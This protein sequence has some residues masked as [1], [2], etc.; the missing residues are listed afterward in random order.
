MKLL[1]QVLSDL[2]REAGWVILYGV[3]TAMVIMA[4]ILIYASYQT[5]EAKNDSISKFT[6][7]GISFVQVG[8]AQYNAPKKAPSTSWDGG[9]EESLEEYFT[10]IFSEN[11]CGGT[12]VF[13]W[14]RCGY[15][16]VIILL[17][18]YT[19]L[20]P[21][22][23][24]EAE[25][26]TFAVSHD[27]KDTKAETITF[28]GVDYPLYTAPENMEIYHPLFYMDSD[29]LLMENTLFVFTKDYELIKSI[30]PKS[31]YWEIRETDLLSR[32]ILASPSQEE[33]VRLRNVV[34]NSI[35]QYVSVQSVDAFLQSTTSSGLRT[36][37]T[38]LLFYISATSILLGAMLVNI[39]RILQRKMPE[40]AVHHL[41][42][43]SERFLYARML[44][45]SVGYH[46][47]PLGACI[48]ILERN[49]MASA[50]TI[51]GLILWVVCVSA[52]LSGVVYRRFLAKFRQGFGREVY[53]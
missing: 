41:F 7:N 18:C 38:Y 26:I 19:D 22:Q 12:F 28:S 10:D 8:S 27:L 17:G 46:I 33:I 21:F 23:T 13:L 40:Y 47:L 53:A 44:L 49:R 48:R 11:G 25:P 14:E 6:A 1:R 32:F 36:H 51:G 29:S 4:F 52:V 39:Y 34:G 35:G 42:G 31:T 50:S 43:A 9:T 2:L 5:V 20:T 16:Q 15:Q 45:F 3:M 24:E 30:F 37:Q